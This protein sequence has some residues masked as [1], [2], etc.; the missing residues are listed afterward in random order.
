MVL[1]YPAGSLIDQGC[2]GGSILAAVSSRIRPTTV[3][4][5]VTAWQACGR[6]FVSL[7]S[8]LDGYFRVLVSDELQ[9]DEW[10]KVLR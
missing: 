6:C 3:E 4:R 5:R 2:S 8:L 9:A 7:L 1:L 10:S